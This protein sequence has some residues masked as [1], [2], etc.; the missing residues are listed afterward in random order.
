M[1]FIS[2]TIV[3]E[4]LGEKV[5]RVIGDRH[6]HPRE[7]ENLMKYNTRRSRVEEDNGGLIYIITGYESDIEAHINDFRIFQ[8]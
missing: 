7:L 4:I 6:L 8:Y 5:R 2:N 3:L 1:E